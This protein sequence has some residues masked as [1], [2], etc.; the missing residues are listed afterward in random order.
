MIIK[1]SPESATDHGSR[2]LHGVVELLAMARL[3]QDDL[4]IGPEMSGSHR[5]P[6]SPQ[7][8][9]Q[10]VDGHAGLQEKLASFLSL[11]ATP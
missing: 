10:T 2:A 5:R 7:W 11:R 1:R 4:Q 3:L 6:M 9:L 8:Q